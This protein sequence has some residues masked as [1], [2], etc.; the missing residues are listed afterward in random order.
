MRYSFLIIVF[1][2]SFRAPAQI[3]FESKIAKFKVDLPTEPTEKIDTINSDFGLIPRYL[4]MAESIDRGR[5]LLYSVEILNTKEVESDLKFKDLKKNY[6]ARKLSRS[7]KI[8]WEL[9]RE[10]TNGIQEPY[11]EELVF[12]DKSGF[13]LFSRIFFRDSKFYTVETFR[14]KSSFK[15]GSRLNKATEDFFDSFE[16]IN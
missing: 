3:I 5:N 1:L 16:L 9:V 7:G 13:L 10:S 6:I 2:I 4:M 8:S 12:L 14:I 11:A 15:I